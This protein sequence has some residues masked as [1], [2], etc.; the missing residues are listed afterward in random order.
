MTVVHVFWDEGT[1]NSYTFAN[2]RAVFAFL[3]AI[4]AH[5]EEELSNGNMICQCRGD[6]RYRGR[7]RNIARQIGASYLIVRHIANAGPP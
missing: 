2:K 4:H 1:V 5:D 3:D 6:N 7:A